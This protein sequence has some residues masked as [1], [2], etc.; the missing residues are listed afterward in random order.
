M[1][2]AAYRSAMLHRRDD[3]PI[4]D[5]HFSDDDGDGSR[6]ES[7]YFTEQATAIKYGI[8]F[9]LLSLGFLVIFGS[10]M[11]A[12]QRMRKGQPPLPYHR[13][14]VPRMYRA[15]F[16]P[17][18][19]VPEANFSFYEHDERHRGGGGGGVGG[20]GGGSG[21]GGGG[22][23]A[24][25]GYDMHAVPP[26]VYNP[27]LAQPPAYPGFSSSAAASSPKP[28]P[29]E[30][31]QHVQRANG[32]GSSGAFLALPPPSVPPPRYS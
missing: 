9:G 6:T 12:R 23:G 8:L 3:V 17:H 14:L 10:W 18:L 4:D 26:P 30:D 5:D 25:D 20:Y 1:S 24:G 7:W 11:H 21:G 16:E 28:N 29:F 15:R 2:A 22:G 32:E 27:H 31:P 19:R 13:W